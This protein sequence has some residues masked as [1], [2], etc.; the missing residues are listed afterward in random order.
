MN[1]AGHFREAE[2]LLTD[3]AGLLGDPARTAP[4]ADIA[5]AMV[6]RAQVHASLAEAAAASEQTQA[7]RLAAEETRRL[8]QVIQ[9]Q[10][11]QP[12]RV[13]GGGS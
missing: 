11:T 8:R 4:L 13:G 3:S 9:A 2:R 1:G 5:Y 6:A 7:L 10:R 12:Q